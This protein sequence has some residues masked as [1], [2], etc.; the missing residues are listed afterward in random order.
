M[1]ANLFSIT[2][3]LVAGLVFSGCKKE[4]TTLEL[5][6]L[7]DYVPLQKGKYITYRLDSTVFTNFGRNTEVHYYQEKHLVDTLLKDNLGRSGYRIFRFLRDT[8]GNGPW[9]PAGSYFVTNTGNTVEWLEDNL[10]QLKLVRPISPD[11]Y[12]KGNRHLPTEPY[13]ALFNFSNDDNMQEWDFN[14]SGVGEVFVLPNGQVLDS[15]IT[16]SQVNESINVPVTVPSA[17][18]SI[19]FAEDKFAKG[20]GLVQQ[21]LIMWEYQ[22]NPGGPSPYRIGFGIKRSMIDHN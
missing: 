1:R 6:P 4:S 13:N 17:Y 3:L 2:L 19:N 15:V 8:A 21:Q 20:V 18:A 12:W 16:V 10:R 7:S 5:E 14:Y 22:P 9:A 11:N